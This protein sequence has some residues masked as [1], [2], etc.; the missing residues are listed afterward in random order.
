VEKSFNNNHFLFPFMTAVAGNPEKAL[1]SVVGR[2]GFL[3]L[4]L[5][6]VVA[7]FLPSGARAMIRAVQNTKTDCAANPCSATFAA[8]GPGHLL[9]V[10]TNFSG[11]GSS[12]SNVSGGGTWTHCSN[13]YQT[14]NQQSSTAYGTDMAYYLPV[15]AA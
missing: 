10:G 4:C 6:C 11:G 5:A 7:A 8:T 14:S 3:L 2:V 9:V 15:L 12:I 13:C 1:R